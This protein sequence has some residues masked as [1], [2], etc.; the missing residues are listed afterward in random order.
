MLKDALLL[1]RESDSNF[2]Y[3][4]QNRLE[5]VGLVKFMN[6]FW[7]TVGDVSNFV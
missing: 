7:R 1:P 2:F 3:L 6:L 4:G 5:L